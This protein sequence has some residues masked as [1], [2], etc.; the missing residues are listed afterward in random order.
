MAQH[1]DAPYEALRKK[2]MDDDAIRTPSS[3]GAST[4]GSQNSSRNQQQQISGCSRH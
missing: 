4:S 1:I 2:G 3:K